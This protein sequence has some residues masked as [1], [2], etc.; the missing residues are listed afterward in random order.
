MTTTDPRV[1]YGDARSQEARGE[2]ARGEE[3]RGEEV[4]AGDFRHTIGHFA[5]GVTVVTSVGIDGQPV[6][7]TAN[8]VSS[9]SLDPPLILVCFDLSSQT[10]EA[11]RVHGAFAVNVL[12]APQQELSSNFA[13]RGLAAAW[14]GV[15]H[16]PGRTGSPRLHGVLATLECT[17]EHCLPG[18]DHEIVV[19]RVRDVETGD[20]D[21]PPLLFWRGTYAALGG[22]PPPRSLPR[23][24]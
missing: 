9:L 12:A 24:A 19:G 15:R 14:D 1:A 11:V 6:G 5:T 23:G 20:A 13:R 3:A 21:A 17:V 18:G 10:L 4:S 8:A 7:T 22:D 16:R 2:E